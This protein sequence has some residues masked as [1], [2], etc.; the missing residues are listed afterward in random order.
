MKD[1]PKL[2]LLSL[3]TKLNDG[4]HVQSPYVSYLKVRVQ[5][6]CIYIYCFT[7][8]FVGFDVSCVNLHFVI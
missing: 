1:C 6:P 4:T 8:S 5:S 3:M 7:L 2:A